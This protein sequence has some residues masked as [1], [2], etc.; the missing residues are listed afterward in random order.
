MIRRLALLACLPCALGCREQLRPAAELAAGFEAAGVEQRQR[1]A[2]QLQRHGAEAVPQWRTLLGSK[3]F[4]VHQ[5]A[6]AALQSLGP[7]AAPAVPELAKFLRNSFFA[8]QK[9]STMNPDER[10]KHPDP[11]RRAASRALAAVGSAALPAIREVLHAPDGRARQESAITLGSMGHTAAPARPDLIA[12]LRDQDRAVAAAAAW[13]LG[14]IGL[15]DPARDALIGMSAAPLW[16][17]RLEALRALVK[18]S[19]GAPSD[20][21]RKA[22]EARR[23]DEHPL[24]RDNAREALAELAKR[25]PPPAGNPPPAGKK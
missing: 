21:L 20:A 11:G 16:I 22:V 23:D 12:A 8:G 14:E 6:A 4:D 15:D 13:A 9:P 5:K 17:V 10:F 25:T 18:G 2:M 7:A 3:Q 1:L 24:V 19:T